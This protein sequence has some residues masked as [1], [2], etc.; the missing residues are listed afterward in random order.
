MQTD[1]EQHVV[2][3][4]QHVNVVDRSV[5][6]LLDQVINLISD[7]RSSLGGINDPKAREAL[8]HCSSAH[9]HVR[10]AAY[11]SLNQYV[12]DAHRLVETLRA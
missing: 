2:E 9:D 8:Q 4:M 5:R 10:N 12:V 6:P 11:G 3:L 1:I 7:A